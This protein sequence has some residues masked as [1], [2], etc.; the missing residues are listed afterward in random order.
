MDGDNLQEQL[1]KEIDKLKE[2]CVDDSIIRD[3]ICGCPSCIVIKA[4]MEDY[5]IRGYRNTL[6][7][8][9]KVLGIYE[10]DPPVKDYVPELRELFT[11]TGNKTDEYKHSE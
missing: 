7:S 4:L 2:F 3:A 8:I 9:A 5:K 10:P 11:P 6:D 1:Q